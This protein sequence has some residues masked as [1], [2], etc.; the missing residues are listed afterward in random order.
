MVP[1]SSKADFRF[2]VTVGKNGSGFCA[3][4]PPWSVNIHISAIILALSDI[5]GRN[6]L[7]EFSGAGRNCCTDK[8]VRS[9]QRTSQF[10]AQYQ[11]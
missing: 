1:S 8:A 3:I 11:K 9:F 6:N 5:L 7:E 2:E 10:L 4:F